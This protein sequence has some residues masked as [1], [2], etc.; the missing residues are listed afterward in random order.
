M[1]RV[2]LIAYLISVPAFCDELK[3]FTTD[4]CSMF[5][6]G[7]MQNNVKWMEC[8]VRHD[9]AY[10][11]GGTENDRKKADSELKQCVS[12]L[13]EN[14]ISSLMHWGVRFG[15]DPYFPTWYRWGYGWPYLRGYRELSETERA[16]VKQRIIELNQLLNEFIDSEI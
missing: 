1:K 3:P 2:I 12:E 6:D 11:K 13:G 14:N 5:P 9:Y 4:G 15:G 10:W 7:N 16:Q 8:C